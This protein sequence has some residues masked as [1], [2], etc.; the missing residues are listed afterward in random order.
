MT[1]GWLLYIGSY[2]NTTRSSISEAILERFFGLKKQLQFVLGGM[3]TGQY[4]EIA[5]RVR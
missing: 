3:E 2:A 4:N 5:Q 1:W